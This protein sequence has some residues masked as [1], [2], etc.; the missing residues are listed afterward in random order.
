MPRCSTL[1]AA[2]VSTIVLL[3]GAPLAAAPYTPQDDSE[4][5]TTLPQ[6]LLAERDELDTLRRQL[7]TAPDN[8]NLATTVAARYI[9]IGDREGDPR[10]YGYAQAA[11]GPWWQDDHAP[12]TV[13]G[14]RAKLK[15]KDHQYQAALDDLAL[16]LRQ[17]PQDAQALIEVVNLHRVLGQYD[18]ARQVI[19]RVRG[20]DQ[21]LTL[22]LCEI[23]LRALTGQAPQA[24]EATEQT[25]PVAQEKFP[26]VLPWLRI[27]QADIA[28]ALG[29]HQAA[30]DHFAQALEQTPNDPTL[31]RA[32]GDFLLQQQRPDQALQ[33]LRDH[34]ADNGILLLAA[35][36][37][38]QSG[39]AQLA[40]Q[41]TDQLQD[42]FEEIRL[43]GGTPHGRFE[44]RYALELRE[45]PPR[46][47]GIALENWD[48]QK[49]MQDA[50][51][52]LAAA[53][54]AGQPDR[55]SPVLEFLQRHA[56]QDAELLRLAGQLEEQP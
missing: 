43:R 28:R 34:T 25:L 3:G 19:Q 38:K 8:A 17:Q 10:F 42:R 2:W 27:T 16:L 45:D 4:V 1:H 44:S 36:A 41:W 35:I 49:E 5:L 32:Y 20:M 31:L 18:E 11:L 9:R 26:G 39:E 46:A 54:A 29:R 37:A 50:R 30:E 21:P 47:L 33:L 22:L 53:L 48:R 12:P 23:P 55:A 40:D 6:S 7:A 56:T 14:L 24:Y 13:L 51:A 15:E 52:V